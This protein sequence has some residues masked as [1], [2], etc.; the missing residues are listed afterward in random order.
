MLAAVVLIVAE[1][2]LSSSGWTLLTRFV[3]IVPPRRLGNGMKFL[4]RA[5]NGARTALSFMNSR[6]IVLRAASRVML[7]LTV[8]RTVW[9]GLRSIAMLKSPGKIERGSI[10]TG[11]WMTSGGRRLGS[12]PQLRAVRVGSRIPVPLR[13]G[14]ATGQGSTFAGAQGDVIVLTQPTINRAPTA[15]KD[16]L[17]CEMARVC[18]VGLTGVDR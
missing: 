15:I 18:G 4:A 3:Q 8:T 6:S 10:A 14:P 5:S 2:P 12:W 11:Y 13:P 7:L 1:A 9:P 17:D 16:V